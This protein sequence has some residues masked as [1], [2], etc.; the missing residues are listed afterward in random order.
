LPRYEASS[1]LLERTLARTRR[2]VAVPDR[3]WSPRRSWVPATAAAALL[4]AATAVVTQWMGL[5]LGT[6]VA[7]APR[8]SELR[9]PVLVG[10]L[11]SRAPASSQPGGASSA[12]DVPPA[13]LFSGTPVGV[14]KDTLFDHRED[15][16]FILD[17]VTV[18]RGRATVTRLPSDIR[19]QQ[20][21]ITF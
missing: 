16:E 1:D 10:A 7:H 15:V 18:N 13:D 19:G 20:A 12:S 9:E 14:A 21:V 5:G 11:A 17:P 4:I 8:P 2:S 3:V 6:R